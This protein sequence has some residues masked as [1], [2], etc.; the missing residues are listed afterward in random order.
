MAE[1]GDIKG[2]NP[3]TPEETQA[4]QQKYQES[5]KL[6][7]ESWQGYVKPDTDL[8]Q[9]KAFKQVM[10]ESLQLMGEMCTV[11]KEEKQTQEKTL[12]TD[13]QAYMNSPSD[14][15]KEKVIDDIEKLQQ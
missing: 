13:Y 2:Q 5:F 11:L 4:Y 9:K 7:R 12:E 1:I 3:L 15:G 8:H 6:F 10:D 14:A